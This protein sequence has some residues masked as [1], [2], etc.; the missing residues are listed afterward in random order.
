VNCCLIRNKLLLEITV[1]DSEHANAAL[2]NIPFYKFT[3]GLW[4][5]CT[6]DDSDMGKQHE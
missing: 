6:L 2:D 3:L 4:N 1:F 5:F